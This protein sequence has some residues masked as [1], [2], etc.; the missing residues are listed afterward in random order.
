MAV[1]TELIAGEIKR[2]ESAVVRARLTFHDGKPTVDLRVFVKGKGG[3]L[4]P[5]E[6]GFALPRSMAPQLVWLVRGLGLAE[7]ANRPD[8][9]EPEAARAESA[10]EKA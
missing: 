10:R 3:A 1:E 5:T 6:S 7:R 4:R 2:G 8:A 9:T